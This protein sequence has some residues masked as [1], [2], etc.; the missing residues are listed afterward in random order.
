MSGGGG[1]SP[2]ERLGKESHERWSLNSVLKMEAG[3]RGSLEAD[4]QDV[5]LLPSRQGAFTACYG[6]SG[7]TPGAL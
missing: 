3:G 2:L 5:P 6:V 7:A 4:A 1:H